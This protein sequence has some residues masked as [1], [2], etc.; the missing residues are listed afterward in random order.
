MTDNHDH[1]HDH[2]EHGVLGVVEAPERLIGEELD[3]AGKSLADALKVS[4]RVLGC[5]MVVLLAAYLASGVFAVKSDERAVISR[6]GRLQSQ[7]LKPGLKFSWPFPVDR[8]IIVNVHE[9]ETRI[10]SFMYYMMSYMAGRDYSQIAAASNSL[11][12]GL[13]GALMT[14]DGGLMH[15]QWNCKYVI[16][17]D[18]DQAVLDYVTRLSGLEADRK[19][20]LKPAERAVLDA[21]DNASIRVAAKVDLE[22]IRRNEPQFTQDVLTLAQ[23]LLDDLKTG[24]R[25]RSLQCIAHVPPLQTRDAF[26]AVTQAEQARSATESNAEKEAVATKLKAAGPNWRPLIEAIGLYERALRDKDAPAADA[27]YRKIDTLL[28][29]EATGGQARQIIEDA[30]GQARQT[31]A[32][33][34]A[35]ADR[36]GQ[37]LPQYLAN[38]ALTIHWEWTQAKQ[39][40]LSREACIKQYAPQTGKGLVLYLNYDPAL[41]R[42][43]KEAQAKKLEAELEAK[44]REEFNKAS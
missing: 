18:D 19:A 4:F 33:A 20:V 16:P 44:K 14:A 36:F 9:Q 8:A 23:K 27:A 41:I 37:L 28:M 38:P 26:N 21:V 22:V 12:P 10:N 35:L 17:A 11:R 2:D 1:H 24:I 6:L 13:D 5:I 39:E 7:V 31:V 32:R 3:P 25:I 40:I 30:K 43:L 34:R 42:R 15:V 29:D